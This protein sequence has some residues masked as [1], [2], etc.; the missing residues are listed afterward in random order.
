MHRFNWGSF[1]FLASLLFVC[2]F[3]G[4]AQ[5]MLGE[6]IITNINTTAV[7]AVALTNNGPFK[8]TKLTLDSLTKSSQQL[9][10]LLTNFTSLDVLYT[11]K[12]LPDSTLVMISICKSSLN[13]SLNK[14]YPAAGCYQSGIY[15]DTTAD[16]QVCSSAA[17]CPNIPKSQFR[18]NVD[19]HGLNSKYPNCKMDLCNITPATTDSVCFGAPAYVTTQPSIAIVSAPHQTPKSPQQS[20][21]SPTQA[22]GRRSGGSIS[23]TSIGVVVLFA[24]VAAAWIWMG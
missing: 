17:F 5:A 20:P 23:R 1:S 15:G 2:L 18:V 14:T 11:S 7:L 10:T 13:A 21:Q 8:G 16:L 9:Q 4:K 19:C 12:V 3:N 6:G 22:P 24:N